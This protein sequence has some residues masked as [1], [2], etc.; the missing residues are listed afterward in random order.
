MMGWI[1]DLWESFKELVNDISDTFVGLASSALTNLGISDLWSD[2]INTAPIQ[3]LLTYAPYSELLIDWN[4]VMVVFT[5]EFSIILSVLIFKVIV[6][7]IP[8]VY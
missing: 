7:L 6:K 3:S 8:T 5:A 4:I 1:S 2:L